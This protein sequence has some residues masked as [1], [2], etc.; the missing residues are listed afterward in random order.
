MQA[1]SDTPFSSRKIAGIL[2]KTGLMSRDKAGEILQQENAVKEQIYRQNARKRFKGLSRN[3]ALSLLTLIDVLLFLK[4][5]RSDAPDK[6]LDEDRIYRALAW[7]WDME[8]RKIDP[9][10]LELSLVT[11]TISKSFAAK[12]QL[13]PLQVEG[14]K[15]VV[16]TPNPFD[17]EAIEDVER[18][19]K[20]KVKPIV[21]SRSDVEKLIQEFFGFHRS[22]SAA[23]DL[24]AARGLDI[25]NLERLTRLSSKEDMPSTDQHIVNAVNHLFSYAF[26]QKASDVHI[27]PKRDVCLVRMRIDGALH[28]AYKLP[29]QLHNAVVSRIKTLSALDMA[30]KRRPQDGRI[31]LGK[32]ETEVEVRVSTIPVAF[33]EKVVMRIMDPDFLFQDLENLGFFKSDFEGYKELISKPFGIVLVTGPTGSGK[34]TT[35][36]SSLKMLSSP[37]VNITTIEDPIEMVHE[38]FNQIAV[39]PAIDV[40]FASVLRNILRQDPDII[41]VGEIRDRETVNSAVQAALTGHLVLSTLHTNDAVSSLFRLMDLGM[42]PYLIQASLN[43]IVAQ[44]LVRKICPHC[45]E[46]FEMDVRELKLMGLDV[47]AQ[48]RVTL[49]H[50]R[51]C[52]KCRQTGYKGRT[53]IYEIMPYSDALKCMTSD[54]AVLD[55][56]RAKAREEGMQLL[57]EGGIRKMLLGQTTY[58]EVLRV[59]WDQT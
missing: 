30:E 50:G 56:M 26:D 9:L 7:A 34:S 15:L 32:D 47:K 58:Q 27:E 14:G 24:F 33:G 38:E 54:N 43:G 12:H 2:V 40:T 42:P 45:A 57:R 37:E 53:G 29:K 22:I 8:Y 11:G 44:R 6:P 10:K 19:S 3:E 13:L 20:L 31:K 51:G 23:E 59:T 35:L 16:A 5:M 52:A 25:G 36:Y 46:T 4:L 39:Q 28:T 17:R 48:G 18:A 55:A 21:S 49:R 1:P 41:M